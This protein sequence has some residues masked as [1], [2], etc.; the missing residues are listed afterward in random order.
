MSD[1][2]PVILRPESFALWLDR[3]MAEV[4]QLRPLYQALPSESLELTPVANI[5]KEDSPRCIAL[6]KAPTRAV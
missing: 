5:H 3:G 4:D 1:R 2:M 6:A